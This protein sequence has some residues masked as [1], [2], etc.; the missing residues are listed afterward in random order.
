MKTIDPEA[1]KAAHNDGMTRDE[2]AE[3]FG[4]TPGSVTRIRKRLGLPLPPNVTKLD[5]DHVKALVEQ[6]LTAR[7][8]AERLECNEATISRIRTELGISHTYRGRPMTETRL[9]AIWQ[10]IFEGWSHEEIHRTE[11]ADVET[12]RRYFPGTAWTHQQAGEYRAILR[13]VENPTYAHGAVKLGI[14]HINYDPLAE[15]RQRRTL[16]AA[17]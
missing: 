17:A 2:L 6:G 9:L 14:N 1:F 7:A 10:M 3:H 12:I 16:K 5:R 8:I 15:R 11:G 13:S 4:I